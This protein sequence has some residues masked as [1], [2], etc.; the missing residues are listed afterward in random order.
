MI[1]KI[2]VPLTGRA[3]DRRALTAAFRVADPFRSHID[4]L[5]VMPP[6]EIHTPVEGSALPSALAEQ[7]IAI[8][9]QDQARVLATTRGLF[10]SLTSQYG[11]V[12]RDQDSAKPA[13]NAMSAGWHEATG[14]FSEIIVQEA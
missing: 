8:G 1:K 2:L 12:V 10:E 9:R 3:P 11:A 13:D 6:V 14:P 5:C 7:L 4:G